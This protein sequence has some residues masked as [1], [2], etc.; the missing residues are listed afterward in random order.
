MINK[1]SLPDAEHKLDRA[2]RVEI[3]KVGILE[4]WTQEE[5]AEKCGVC[6][7]T[8]NRDIRKWKLT[9]GLEDFIRSKWLEKLEI[10]EDEDIPLTFKELSK[11]VARSMT[12]RTE[13]KIEGF[14]LRL[15]WTPGDED[16]EEPAE[17][18]S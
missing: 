8:I 5:I 7:E 14:E 10:I 9:G 4:G 13:A 12:Q 16:E 3:I 1:M 6:R 15:R 2:A 17:Q 18:Q 11:L